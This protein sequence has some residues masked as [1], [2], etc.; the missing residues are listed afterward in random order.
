MNKLKVGFVGATQTNFGAGAAGGKEKLFQQCTEDLKSYS[1][2]FDFE[3]YIYPELLVTDDDAIKAKK[4]LETE[5]IDFLLLQNTTFS[6]GEVVIRLA[7]INAFLGLWALP[8]VTGKGTVF[9]DSINSF[10]GLNMYNSIVSHYLKDYHIK[11]KWFYGKS[12]NVVFKRR[13]EITVRALTALKKLRESRVALVGGIAPGFNDLYFD[14][15]I[16]QKKLG[17]EINRGHEFAEIEKRARS[18]T[19]SEL[20]PV[21]E[22]ACC[23]YSC[24]GDASSESLDIHTRFYKA[25]MDFCREYQYDALGVSCW[26]QMGDIFDALSC[27]VI[28]KLNQNGIPA[29]C[30]GD[31]PGAVSMLMLKYIAERPA[32]LMDLSGLDDE[33]QTLL[34]WHCGPSP[35]CYAGCDGSAMTYSYQPTATTE[36]MKRG[37]INDMVFK[38]QH[39]TFMRVT[40]EW[41]KIFLL[42]GKAIDKTKDSPVGSRGW[43]GDLRLN[44]QRISTL[45]L[46]NTILVQGMQH[47]YPMMS[48]DITEELLELAAWLDLKPVEAVGYQNY[49]QNKPE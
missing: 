8:E 39:L 13:L 33:D 12:D 41:D 15:R 28:G 22:I 31:L 21:K 20:E 46:A 18:Y 24:K 17:I 35:E 38:P 27:S 49:L 30:E 9:I 1:K 47:H 34:M 29:A 5:K 11:C 44:R 19:E 40:G 43:I 48:G 3:L 10:C 42:D 16:G 4:A 36:L 14:E 7:K 45:D 37:L 6:A 23:G 25:Y 26:P 2:E 32:T